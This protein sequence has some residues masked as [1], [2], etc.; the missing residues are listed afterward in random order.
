[1]SPDQVYINLRDIARHAGLAQAVYQRQFDEVEQFSYLLEKCASRKDV[2]FLLQGR[3]WSV[4][5]GYASGLMEASEDTCNNELL[6]TRWAV[7]AMLQDR[8][9]HARMSL[10]GVLVR[11][12]E[13]ASR[14]LADVLVSRGSATHNALATVKLDELA[15]RLS[16]QG[17]IRV[18]QCLLFRRLR[19]DI[20]HRFGIANRL[21]EAAAIQV[22]FACGQPH[23][24]D[25]E[26]IRMSPEHAH[27]LMRWVVEFFR[28]TTGVPTDVQPDHRQATVFDQLGEP[29]VP[30]EPPVRRR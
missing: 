18:A 26:R 6:W 28:E 1:M 4:C 15:E 29:S 10:E 12:Y 27:S 13:T 5:A 17:D 16:A 9:A 22:T 30:L 3:I 19:N 14:A 11:F 20:V 23:V 2:Q 21:S 8:R 7:Q 25:G 24:V